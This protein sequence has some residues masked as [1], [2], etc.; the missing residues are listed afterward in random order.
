MEKIALFG[1]SAD[2]P[3]AAHQAI[4]SWLGDNYDRVLVWASDNPFK[5]HQTNLQQRE[6]MLRLLIE[7]IKPQKTNIK[8]YP[9]LSHTRTWETV[10]QVRKT[11]QTAAL[12]LVIGSDLIQQ[13]P[14][15]YLAAELFEQVNLSIVPR[16]GNPIEATA[17]G[18]LEEMGAKIAIAPE[19]T[20]N[21][22]STAYREEK[23]PETLTDTVKDYIDREQL[24][25][26]PQLSK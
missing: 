4:I 2:P 17:L 14:R 21:V 16:A 8:V 22:S 7:D 18:K 15:W 6:A 9:E 20:P 19:F 12:T 5:S 23:D 25:K 11:W 24:Y 13:L 1:T 3:T 10:Q 26:H